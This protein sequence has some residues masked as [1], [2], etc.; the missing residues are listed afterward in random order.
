[1]AFHGTESAGGG[2]VGECMGMIVCSV[3]IHCEAVPLCCLSGL[4]RAAS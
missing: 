3:D 4:C 2:V 1:M